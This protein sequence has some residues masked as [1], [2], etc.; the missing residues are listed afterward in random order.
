ME[1]GI[2]MEPPMAES[3]RAA[4]FVFLW[5]WGVPTTSMWRRR[6][7]RRTTLSCPHLSAAPTGQKPR[8]SE[9]MFC[10]A[11]ARSRRSTVLS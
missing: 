5:A 1:L 3:P 10:L 11:P 6:R 4:P 8:G 7:R 9:G 2:I